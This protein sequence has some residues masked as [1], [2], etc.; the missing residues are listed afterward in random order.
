[1]SA[2][3]NSWFIKGI[4]YLLLAIFFGIVLWIIHL[5]PKK[6][7]KKRKKMVHKRKPAKKKGRK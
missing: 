6:V 7:R 2:L 1:M 5:G 4:G 3:D